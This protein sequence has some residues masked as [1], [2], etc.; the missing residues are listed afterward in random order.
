[1]ID[2]PGTTQ[3]TITVGRV[4]ISG[5]AVDYQALEIICTVLGGSSSGR[6]NWNLRDEKGYTYG[7][8]SQF[9][10]RKGLSPFLLT[11]PVQA[12]ATAESLVELMKEITDLAGRRALREDQIAEME[13]SSIPVIF[14]RY[15]TSAGIADQIRDLII[16]NLG[17]DHYASLLKAGSLPAEA[18]IDRVAKQYLKPEEMTILVVGDRS[19]IEGSLKSL[20]IVKSIRLLDTQGNPFPAPVASKPALAGPPDGSAKTSNE[21]QYSEEDY[22]HEED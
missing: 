22:H 16:Y 3:S 15:E 14:S 8:F 4:G 20:P 6:I 10:R 1:L 13:A 19:R 2:R 7:L 12:S 21:E 11:G 5:E 9:S 17:D 18:E